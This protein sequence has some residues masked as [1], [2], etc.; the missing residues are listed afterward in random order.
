MAGYTNKMFLTNTNLHNATMVSRSKVN[1]EYLISQSVADE[2]NT[3]RT[4][5][6][7]ATFNDLFPAE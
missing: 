5:G 3:Y 7:F 4:F 2:L 6:P 1:R